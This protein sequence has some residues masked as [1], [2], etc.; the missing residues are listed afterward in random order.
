MKIKRQTV[1]AIAFTCWRWT[2]RKHM[3]E[4]AL[5]FGTMYFRAD[6]AVASIPGGFH[7][8]F[9][10]GEKGRPPAATFVFGIRLKKRRATSGTVV[11]PGPLL[12][13]QRAGTG[14]FRA[15]LAQNTL[16]LRCQRLPWSTA[17]GCA[18]FRFL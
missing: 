5:A 18:A 11:N 1:H 8:A 4:M 15:M 12:I 3:A 17:R 7:S 13:I 16:L 2:V 9:K 14:A 6:H 10:R